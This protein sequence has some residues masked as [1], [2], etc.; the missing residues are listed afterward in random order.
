MQHSVVE[1]EENKIMLARV[2]DSVWSHHIHQFRYLWH[3]PFVKDKGRTMAYVA[4]TRDL[5][6]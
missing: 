2:P 4:L 5:M 6:P 1:Q 3:P